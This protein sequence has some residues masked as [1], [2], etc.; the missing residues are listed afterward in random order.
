MLFSNSCSTLNR[1][2]KPSFSLPFA[3]NH[4]TNNF[5]NNNNLGNN[6]EEDNAEKIK[7]KPLK[8]PISHFVKIHMFKSFLTSGRNTKN[9]YGLKLSFFEYLKFIISSL[10]FLRK[11]PKE[12]LISKA[13][14]VFFKDMDIVNIV[15][16]M[17]D[18][19]N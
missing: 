4:H 12:I 13:E 1:K 10:L 5:E 6:K 7:S 16:K 8:S 3:N 19:E 2:A 17:Q 14:K 11:S 9:K 18:L 15:R